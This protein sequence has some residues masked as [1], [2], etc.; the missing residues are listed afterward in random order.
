[1]LYDKLI[2]KLQGLKN[3]KIVVSGPQRSGTRFATKCLAHDLG[4]TYIDE[5]DFEIDNFVKA[6]NLCKNTPQFAMQA[7]ALSHRLQEFPRTIIF[8]FM[9]RNVDDILASQRRI[10]W[11]SGHEKNISAD[12]YRVFAELL[13]AHEINWNQ[14]QSILKYQV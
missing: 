10:G 6:I 4:I 7:P 2:K 8:I 13:T 11:W 1:M 3:K 12:Y 14:T 9:I 5:L